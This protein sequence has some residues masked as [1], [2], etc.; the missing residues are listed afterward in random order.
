MEPRADERDREASVRLRVT[1]ETPA[2]PLPNVVI[3]E[4]RWNDFDAIREN[5]MLLYEERRENP[6]IGITLFEDPPSY[7]DEVGWFA[8]LYRDVLSGISIVSVADRDGVAVGQCTV[9]REGPPGESENAHVGHLGIVVHRD[10]RGS[11]AGRALMRHALAEC[12]GKFEV[13]RLSV[14]SVNVRARKLYEEMGFV[15]LGTI[16]RAIHRGDR[17]L[18]EDLMFKVIDGPP[19]NR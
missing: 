12:R 6:E 5:Y 4:L 3:R 11:G 19:A 17:Y 15:Y 10:H 8:G 9:R 1:P 13:V 2:R 18:D 16:P 7:S 14:F